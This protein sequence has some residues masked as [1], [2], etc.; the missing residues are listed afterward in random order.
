[1]RLAATSCHLHR[2]Y[3]RIIHELSRKISRRF[4]SHNIHW[5]GEWFTSA[6]KAHVYRIIL[7]IITHGRRET[8]KYNS[9]ITEDSTA[10]ANSCDILLYLKKTQNVR[11]NMMF[12]L[13]AIIRVL[14]LLLLL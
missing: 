1:M 2:P 13:R 10:V 8:K 14:H 7:L 12:Y 4:P 3:R 5:L 11:K 6:I 9:C